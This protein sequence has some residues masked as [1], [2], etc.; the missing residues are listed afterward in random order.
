MTIWHPFTQHALFP[1]MRP[2]ASAQGAWLTDAGGR[3]IFDAISSWWVVTHGHCHPR[4]VQAIRDQAGRLD[5][6]IFAGYTHEPAETFARGLLARVPQNLTRVFFSDSG[7]TAVEVALKMALGHFRHQ[8]SPRRR[9]V[10]MQDGYHGDTVGTMSAGERGA[11]TQ[12]YDPLLFAVDRIP[13]PTEQARQATL[14]ALEHFCR[15]PE[16][17]ALL[18]EPLVLGAGGMRI[19]PQ[20]VLT[21]MAAICAR[22]GV[23]LIA[24]EVMT[25]WGRTGRFLACDHVGVAPDIL[26]L[27]KGITGGHLPLAVTLC[28]EDI[29][30]SHLS[31]D[32]RR[33]F[34]HSSSYT[35]NPIACA[36]ACA[37]LAIWDDEPVQD[38]IDA[39]TAAQAQ[40]ALRLARHPGLSGVRQ[41]GTILAAEVG[42]GNDYM[43]DTGP[44]LMRFFAERD[45][46]IR[47]LGRTVYLLPPY[48]ATAAELSACH[49]AI[50][51][52]ADVF[53]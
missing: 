38:R 25:G 21:E 10:V 4:I 8:G 19:Y 35:A 6:V 43:A 33:T 30:Q 46:L 24:D 37:N 42:Q 29:Y 9:I 28:R 11:F 26:C 15:Q 41:I 40:G 53:G 39:V 32:R 44:A 7:S 14:D 34:F 52:A 1:T 23:L 3:R 22:H 31:T 13:F 51:E 50:L 27:S 48:C 17:A 36:A 49:D 16:T 20:D 45:L 47:P 18:I 12:P 2:I 5:Q